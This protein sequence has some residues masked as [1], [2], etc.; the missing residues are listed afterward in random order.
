MAISAVA[1]FGLGTAAR[2]K[3]DDRLV[4][5]KGNYVAD[6]SPSDVLA[7]YVVRS[8]MAHAR[9]SLQNLD[10]VR[11]APGVHLV[12]SAD[13]LGA[14]PG[15]PCLTLLQQHDGS[16]TKSADIPILCKDIVRHVGDAVA[17][18]VA[19]TRDLA[20]D[21]AE[22]LVVDYDPLSAVVD[23]GAAKQD[24][25]PLVY[26]DH[27]SNIAFEYH[28]G[29]RDGTDAAFAGAHK[30]I[31]LTIVN[32]RVVTNYMEPRAAVGEYD[33]QSERYKL[34]TVT[35]G[36]HGLHAVMAK[37]LG[38]EKDAIRIITP[39]DVGGGFGTK[40]FAYRE[41]PLVCF[42]ARALGRP[43]R[44]VSDRLEHFTADA[45]GRDNITTL[46][47]ALDEEYRFLALRADLDANMGAYLNAFAP[48]I[49]WLGLS[50]LT[51]VYDIPVAFARTTGVYTNTLMVD[52]YRGAGRPEAAYHLERLVDHAAFELGID[53]VSLRERNYIP[54]EKIPYTTA[55][56]RTYDTGDF[57]GLLGAALAKADI[58]GFATRAKQ[59]MDAGKLRGF[60]F[61]SYV[62]ACA[63][64]GSEDATLRLNDDGS[65]TFMIGT[66]AA[67]QGHET[68]YAQFIASVL[69]V[70][71]ERIHVVQGD[72]DLI[73]T[74][75]GTGGSRSIPIGGV[76]AHNAANSMAARIRELAS[77]ALEAAAGDLEIADGRVVI[78]GTDRGLDLSELASGT[79][80]KSRLTIANTYKT[81]APTYPNGTHVCE[82]EVDPQTG[83]VDILNYTIVDDFGFVVNPMLLE[84]QVHGGVAQGIGQALHERT[85]YADDGQ[86]LTATFMDYT[87]PRAD[88]FPKFRFSTRN[89]PTPTN[90]FG[91]KGAG[92]AG[93]IGATPA[94]MNAVV[95]ALN[96]GYGITHMD[97]PATPYAIWQTIRASGV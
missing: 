13:D 66:Q 51:G 10:A 69:D 32:N 61:A 16:P 93:T 85:V 31:S 67:G 46:E 5:G 35:Q 40:A 60:G 87:M 89:I 24:G 17:L 30:V 38:I 53:R 54:M 20:R 19:D 41:Y 62:E 95:D 86:L 90:P 25:A 2:R 14:M 55:M 49:P 37:C 27:G 88:N 48:F 79:A 44:W 50:M 59:S 76:T 84:G 9:F 78:A 91:I 33:P 8:D 1:K 96:R 29:D 82:V 11:S 7:A 68:A 71:L 47:L 36:P 72:T 94:I 4:T 74:G 63:F 52:A 80:D 23:M 45:Q 65:F 39:A 15:L 77:D 34:T 75:G 56:D 97:M 28:M 42:A 22:A 18:I 64:E 92:E 83:V 73:A 3:E 81:D 26:P 21:A 58:D 43:V 70:P 6:Y 12:L 57:A